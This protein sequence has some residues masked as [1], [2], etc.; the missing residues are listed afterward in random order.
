M[1][2][3]TRLGKWSAHEQKLTLELPEKRRVWP[4]AE[5]LMNYTS[6]I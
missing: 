2:P 6:T 4:G 3:L 1:R 5:F